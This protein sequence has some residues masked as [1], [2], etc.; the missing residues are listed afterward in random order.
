MDREL[1][2]LEFLRDGNLDAPPFKAIDVK[3]PVV[4]LSSGGW[5]II[6]TDDSPM[7]VV[8]RNAIDE[9]CF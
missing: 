6:G 3:V 9:S 5:C 2:E 8:V 4:P 7:T 1:E